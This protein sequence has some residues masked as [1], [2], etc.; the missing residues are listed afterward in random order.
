M[1]SDQCLSTEREEWFLDRGVLRSCSREGAYVEEDWNLESRMFI[2]LSPC[3]AGQRHPMSSMMETM[4]TTRK[5]MWKFKSIWPYCVPRNSFYLLV[6][7]EGK[8]VGPPA[9]DWSLSE[10]LPILGDDLETT[11]GS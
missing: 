3:F 4:T 7:W 1:I 2:S 10:V 11:S 6:G 8:G 5:V 9:L